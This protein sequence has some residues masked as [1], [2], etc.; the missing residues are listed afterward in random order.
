MKLKN[1]RGFSWASVIPTFFAFFFFR[2]INLKLALILPLLSSKSGLTGSKCGPFISA[3]LDTGRCVIVEGAGDTVRLGNETADLIT[4]DEN[5]ATEADTGAVEGAV[6]GGSGRGRSTDRRFRER[7]RY[8]SKDTCK[9]TRRSKLEGRQ[10][11]KSLWF[12][13]GNGE[14]CCLFT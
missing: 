3:T 11:S 5:N 2:K 14:G 9:R 1:T 12:Q 7:L 4:D 8:S 6:E 10:W 13:S